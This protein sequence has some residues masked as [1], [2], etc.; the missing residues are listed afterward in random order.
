MPIVLAAYDPEW[1]RAF[2]SARD[3]LLKALG[4]DCFIG[5]E[6]IGSTSVPAIVA[7]PIIDMLASLPDL[8][9][10]DALVEPLADL[11][12]RGDHVPSA[13]GRESFERRDATGQATEHLHVVVHGGRRWRS[14]LLF[15][16]W[17]RTHP[18]DRLAYETLK[19]HLAAIH[20]DT[21]EYSAAKTEFV[22]AVLLRAAEH[23]P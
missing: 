13:S 12:Y 3:E 7:K 21:T 11:G 16:D 5:F 19:C 15:R 20:D 8:A 22:K 17:L 14:A 4:A 2:C 1:P 9:R 18:S 23:R 10:V 6:H